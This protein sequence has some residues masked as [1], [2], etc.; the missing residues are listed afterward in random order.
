MG[1]AP[2]SELYAVIAEWA[3]SKGAKDIANQPGCWRG[4]CGDFVITINP[5]SEPATDEHGMELGPFDCSVVAPK[6]VA[7]VLLLNPYG[8]MGTAGMEPDVIAALKADMA[9]LSPNTR[10]GAE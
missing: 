1:G 5:H 3:V 2:I 10:G 4:Q 9:S 7:A 6:Y 8:G